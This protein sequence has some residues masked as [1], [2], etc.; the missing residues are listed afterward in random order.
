MRTSNHT[1]SYPAR[2]RRGIRRL[3]T[4]VGALVVAAATATLTGCISFLPPGTHGGA[5]TPPA[6]E[7]AA[8]GPL[9][10]DPDLLPGERACTLTEGNAPWY[11]G[12]AAFEVHDSDRT[13]LYGC[14]SF[15]GDTGGD[16]NQVF[17][18]Q[19]DEIYITPYNIVDRGPDELYVYGG[20]YGD[21]PDA[22]G[23]FVSRVEPSTF[24]E[25]WRRVL[26]NT[27]VTGEWNY[28]GVLN[29]LATDD[30]IVI[31][32]YRIAKLDPDTGEVLASTTLPTGDSDPGDTA[33]NGY[34]AFPDGT[35]IAKTVNRQPGCTEQGFSAFLD[36]PDPSSAPASVLV[37]IDPNTL[38]ILDQVTLPEMMG[39]RVTTTVFQGEDVI[40]LPGATKLYRYTWSNGELAPDA[41]WGPVDYLL[42]GQTAASA[43]AV[44][45][46]QV[47]GM[48]NG[49]AP[50]STPMSVF[51]VS[52]A[53]SSQ[54]ANLQPFAD[55]GAKN[56]FIPSMVS[57]DP[58]N[59]RVYVMDAGA[60]MLG[61]VDVGD[62]EL[63]LAWSADQR[64]LSFTTLI[65]P[66]DDR[67][68]I[69]THIPVKTF[70]GL[71]DYTTEE[72]VW[73]DADSGDELA[74][75]SVLPK[76]T[77][78]ILVT[79]GFGG[80]QYFLTADGHIIGLQVVPAPPTASPTPTP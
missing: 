39:G 77:T 33:Y 72:V 40:Y 66:A 8:G 73:R 63:T 4:V 21:N 38:E 23:S 30:L 64:T 9:V 68:L 51:A 7:T 27:H 31:Y 50:T 32:G 37:A 17:A 11:P 75:S 13:H 48:T 29:S 65:G 55:S 3:G 78:G 26:I 49:G 25:V 59:E 14:A 22:S 74:R 58:E 62:S 2:E 56:S 34:D 6:D 60:A 69:G 15:L 67:V 80:L 52:Q 12:M 20:G 44:I 71:Q 61:G 54:V 18:Y 46:D 45:G 5:S 57:V 19:S 53:D 28:P 76:M 79:P 43:M 35:L 47:V 70:Q 16:D 10:G 1:A 24:N 36:C 42:D 41:G